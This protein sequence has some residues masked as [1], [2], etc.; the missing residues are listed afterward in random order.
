[1][2]LKLMTGRTKLNSSEIDEYFSKE[3][4]REY[5]VMSYDGRRYSNLR[6]LCHFLASRL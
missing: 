2:L 4:I 1:M 3:K 5:S 6:A